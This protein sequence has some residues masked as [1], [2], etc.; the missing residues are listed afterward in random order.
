MH[1]LERFYNQFSGSQ[2]NLSVCLSP[3]IGTWD[4]IA[5]KVCCKRWVR[6]ELAHTCKAS[7]FA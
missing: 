5:I 4:I 6:D 1:S 3:Q 7:N 2:D